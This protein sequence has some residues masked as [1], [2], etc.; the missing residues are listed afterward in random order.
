MNAFAQVSK[1]SCLFTEVGDGGERPDLPPECKSTGSGLGG[2][3]SPG[4]CQQPPETTFSTAGEYVDD[5]ENKWNILFSGGF[6]RE[7]MRA[8]WEVFHEIDCTG[9]LQDLNGLRV[10]FRGGVGYS[11]QNLANPCPPPKGDGVSP[12]IFLEDYGD[13]ANRVLIIHEMTHVWQICIDNGKTNKGGIENAIVGDGNRL[14]TY[15]QDRCPGL[16]VGG[17]YLNEDHAETIAY[18]LNPSAPDSSTCGDGGKPEN[19]YAGGAFPNHSNLAN[20]AVGKK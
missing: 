8:I 15:S 19:P 17:N 5:I 14:T 6:S 4:V 1:T 20:S 9:F 16:S 11:E 18:Y 2:G 10:E 3:A 13:T 7:H 12:N